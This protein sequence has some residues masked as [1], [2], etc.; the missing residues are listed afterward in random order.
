M[1]ADVDRCTKSSIRRGHLWFYLHFHYENRI[2]YSDGI[3]ISD[4]NLPE[5]LSD[6]EVA[7]FV[8]CV[9]TYMAQHDLAVPENLPRP[10]PDTWATEVQ[11]PLED[12]SLVKLGRGELPR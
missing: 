9:E 7:T 12:D 1:Y 3:E 2:G 5:N 8:A 4:H 10:P 6:D 11:F